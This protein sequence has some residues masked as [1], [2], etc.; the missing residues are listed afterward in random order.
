MQKGDLLQVLKLGPKEIR[1]MYEKAPKEE[2]EAFKKMAKEAKS[3]DSYLEGSKNHKYEVVKIS[4]DSATVKFS[5][6]D[7][8]GKADADDIDLLKE[9]GKWV[10]AQ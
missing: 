6:V 3:S 5:Y 10:I 7:K 4:A 2:K 9:D 8:S 1:E